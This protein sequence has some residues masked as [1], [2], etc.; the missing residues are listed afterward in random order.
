MLIPFGAPM[1]FLAANFN[2]YVIQFSMVL[3][4][5]FSTTFLIFGLHN[6]VCFKIGL[7]KA[8]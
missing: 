1:L 2:S 5:V 4:S 3:I 7:I 8:D 6:Y